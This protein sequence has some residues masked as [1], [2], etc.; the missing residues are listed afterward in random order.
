MNDL[1]ARYRYILFSFLVL[2]L[3]GAIGYGMSHRPPPLILNVQPPQPTPLPTATATPGPVRC[4]VVG[5]VNNPGVYTLPP[6]ARVQD[7]ISAAGGPGEDADLE[8][9]NLATIVQ[10]QQQIIIPAQGAAADPSTTGTDQEKDAPAIID[11][12]TA[13]NEML[14]TLPGIGPALSARIIDY[15]NANGPFETIEDLLAVKGIG[16]KTLE[17]LRPWITITTAP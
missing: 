13:D 14:Q 2:T 5:A 7:A 9:V 15:R 16:E 17:K 11:I 6:A 10:D 1:L 8:Q 4:H 3:I 12:N